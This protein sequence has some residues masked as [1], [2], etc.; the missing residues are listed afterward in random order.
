M[1]LPLNISLNLLVCSLASSV[2]HGQADM[3]LPMPK[4]DPLV[5]LTQTDKTLALA[6][7]TLVQNV[8]PAA[9]PGAKA[10]TD[11]VT[12]LTPPAPPSSAVSTDAPT[13]MLAA[14]TPGLESPSATPLPTLPSEGYWVDGAPINDVLQ[15]LCRKAGYQY[16]FNNELNGPEYIVTGHL[17]LDD[18]ERQIEDLAVAFGLAVYRQAK[19]L[20]VMNDLQL[21]KL[22]LEIMSYQLK[23]LRG[24]SPS[25]VSAQSSAQ[26]SGGEGGG[27]MSSGMADF[28]KLKLIIRPLLTKSVGQIE[29]E[30][31]T[32]TLLVTDNSV[33]IKRI[34]DLLEKIDRPKQQIAVNVR[35]L[36]V[37]N[38]KGKKVGVDW[39][40]TLGE[41]LTVSASQS[42]NAMFN[43]PDTSTLTKASST[44]K[45]F[46]NSFNNQSTTTGGPEGTS[47]SFI[48]TTAATGS[49]SSSSSSDHSSVYDDGPGLVFE[50]L[51]VNA[52]IRALE[53]NGIVSQESCPTIITEDNEQGLISIVDRFPIV[54]STITET[55]AGQN[56]TEEL[57]YKIDE[58]DPDAMEEPEKSREIGVT[59]SV[60]PTLLPDG[61][62][63]MKLRP[64]VA[65][66]VEFINGQTGNIYPRVSE[67]TAEAISRIPSGQSLILGGFY[68]YSDSKNGNNVPFLGKVPGLGWLFKSKD[69]SVEKVS[70]IFVITPSV[71][72]ASSPN[73]IRGMNQEM[74][75]YSNF[76]AA[77]L[78]GM[79]E[80]F[81]PPLPVSSPPAA[82]QTRETVRTQT[83]SKPS[84][85]LPAEGP[86]AEQPKKKNWFGRI[87]SK[88]SNAG[89]TP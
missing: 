77:R 54:T 44:L 27:G 22:P 46:S 55:T 28:E 14:A 5:A 3:P 45:D 23:Y 48:N 78:D 53:E 52:I 15:Y 19:T 29:F 16:F 47:T 51:Q 65:K 8:S 38:T 66:I 2:L 18:P 74:R 31:K 56:I 80:R 42:L 70:L 17:Q 11:S 35:V 40:T 84:G 49:T 64:R 85:A 10:G 73:A 43:L 58:D 4:H 26:A 82:Y 6:E 7:T 67:S 1:N 32:N 37:I 62:V 89:T 60:T 21:S 12:P 68:D 86:Q 87:F 39:S 9:G 50:P 36:R 59:L 30:E 61:T 33:K 83:V 88:N 24:S 20:Y 79:S 63:R 81:L 72:D 34:K 75:T 69:N 13:P 41:G 71:Y 76:E 25:R 57:R